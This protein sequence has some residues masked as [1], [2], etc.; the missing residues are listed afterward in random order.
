M[1]RVSLVIALVV[2]LAGSAPAQ[3]P[4]S[5]SGARS[6]GEGGCE[7]CHANH[8]GA[9]GPYTLEVGDH[10][11]LISSVRGSAQE[12]GTISLSCLRCHLTPGERT[13]QALTQRQTSAIDVE[14]GMYLGVDL[15]D[16][17]PLG[18]IDRS[19]ARRL[20]ASWRDRPF[21]PPPSVYRSQA[22]A[23][24]ETLECSTCHDPHSRV[25]AKPEAEE[26]R[27]L[28]SGCH[29]PARYLLHGH[30][31]LTCSDCHKVHGGND[32]PLLAEPFADQ[33]CN[34]C[35]DSG[36]PMLGSRAARA[37]L[38]SAPEGHREPP[39]QSCTSCHG[40]HE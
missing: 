18:R 28:C 3:H 11:G 2:G 34:S 12:L 4:P 32:V 33:L 40:V 39:T 35:H 19:A 17:H 7:M 1:R 27:A 15:A 21:Q 24:T 9:P 26:E 16:D 25:S 38:P 5:A 22:L 30:A 31:S 23:Q 20:D 36:A 13:R 8:S 29:D 14:N 37:G 6:G 10:A